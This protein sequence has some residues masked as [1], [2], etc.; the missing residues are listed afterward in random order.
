MTIPNHSKTEHDKPVGHPR[1]HEPVMAQE[2]VQ[3]L[4]AKRPLRIVDATVGTGGHAA[5]LLA[6]APEAACLLGLDRDGTALAVAAKTLSRFG[7][8]VIL[9]HGD[10]ADLTA[11]M[12]HAGFAEI[13]ALLADLGMSSFVLDD[14]N[15]GFSLRLDGPLDMR[16]DQQS[17][18]CAKDLVNDASEA[19]LA[20]I[21][22]AYGQEPAARR[23]ARAIVTARRH[24][25]IATTGE[26]RS[27]VEGVRG[28]ARRGRIHPATR[29]FQALRIA[30]NHELEQLGWMLEKAPAL[31]SPSGRIAIIAYHSLEDRPVKKRFL[32]LA[33]SGE[34]NMPAGR[35]LRP[36]PAEVA[37]NARARSARL[38]CLA[39]VAS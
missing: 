8:R 5:A 11:A 1:A 17:P 19:E 39:R 3:F 32:E 24:R 35:L 21:I 9:H 38:R 14:P 25:E 12:R 30:V 34:F 22:W 20:R 27:I 15:R 31:L 7:S 10:F 16:M 33:A 13:D 18:T 28:R 2:V 23:I 6:A 37:R 36:C 4:C 29:T 26:L